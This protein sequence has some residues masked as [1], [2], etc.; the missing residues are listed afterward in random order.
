[1]P[2]YDDKKVRLVIIELYEEIIVDWYHTYVYEFERKYVHF[3]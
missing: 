3:D 1:M 2:I